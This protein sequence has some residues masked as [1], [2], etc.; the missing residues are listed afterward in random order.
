MC[1]RPIWNELHKYRPYHLTHHSK[2]ATA[3]DPDLCLV[4][5]L[6][7]TRHSLMRK[8]LR[9]LSGVTGLIFLLG[10]LIMHY[11]VLQ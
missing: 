8:C 6:P 5:G 9:D 11:G 2:T 3:E 7:T 10:C 1:A 4:S